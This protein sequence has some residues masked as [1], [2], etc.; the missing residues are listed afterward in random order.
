MCDQT[1]TGPPCCGRCARTGSP[2]FEST[3]SRSRW[4][5]RTSACPATESIEVIVDRL[6]RGKDPA[7]RRADS[8]E[9][10]FE[11]GMGRCRMIAGD[12]SRTYIRGWRCA[13]CGTDAIEPQPNLFRYNSP[14]GACPICEGFGRT[15][16]LDLTRIVP[17]PSRTIRGGAGP[18]VD[19]GLSRL[20]SSVCLM[21]AAQLDIPVD[22]PFRSS[23]RRPGRSACSTEFPAADFAGLKAFF[24]GLERRSFKLNVR[25]FLSR[26]RRYQP[27]PGCHGARLRPEALAV[28]IEG[29]DIAALSA[30]TIRDAR[31][32]SRRPGEPCGSSRPRRP[33]LAQVDS[34]LGYLAEIGLDYLTLDRP[35]RTLSAGELQRVSLTKTL[36]SGLVNTLYVLD[37]PTLGLH[38]HDVGKLIAIL[39]RLRDRGNT[40]VV[41]EHDHDVI[42]GADHVVDLG[43]GA[44][45]AGGQVLYSGPLAGLSQGRGSATGDYLSRRKQRR[46]PGPAP[47]RARARR[48]GWSAPAA[49]I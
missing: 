30:M 47:A 41:V 18:V 27:C 28:K 3:A 11:K 43:P 26:W 34:R 39:N 25:A 4:T 23:D 10:A 32:V 13:T 48:S 9:T 45:A 37:E 24:K 1:P 31:V 17:D 21:N 46:R 6:V 36:G 22:V 5:T 19:A 42:R 29:R 2:G 35:A 49:T 20:P 40:L 14:L 8:I 12:E 38:P 7:Q 16:E 33:I 44:G 15:M